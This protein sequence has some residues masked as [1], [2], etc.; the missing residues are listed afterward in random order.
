MEQKKIPFFVRLKRAVINFDEYRTFAEEKTRTAVKYF[1]KLM[2]IF[3]IIITIA[4]TVRVLNQVNIIVESLQN[5][6]PEFSFEDDI[7]ILE[8]ETTRIV[9]GDSDGYFGIILDSEESDLSDIDES[10]DY[11]RI[12]AFLKDRLIIRDSSQEETEVTY[13]QLSSQYD[14]SSM[15]KSAILEFLLRR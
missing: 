4:L 15:N 9:V 3:T 1:L 11:E 2:L 10:G 14:L 13:E 6:F 5:D 12:V 8:G 7:L